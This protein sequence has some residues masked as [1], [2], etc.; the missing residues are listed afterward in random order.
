MLGHVTS[1]Y[2]RL[3]KVSSGYVTFGLVRPIYFML[4]NVILA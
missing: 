2:F 3:G 1:R 4:V